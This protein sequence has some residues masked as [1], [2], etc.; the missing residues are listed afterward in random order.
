MKKD[1]VNTAS[2]GCF[3][4]SADPV[5]PLHL[6]GDEKHGYDSFDMRKN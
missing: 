5:W 1:P 6:Y 3:E 4:T 2:I